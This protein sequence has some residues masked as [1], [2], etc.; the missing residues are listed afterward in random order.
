MQNYNNPNL[1]LQQPQSNMMNGVMGQPQMQSL[2]GNNNMLLG[3]NPYNNYNYMDNRRNSQDLLSNQF[4]KCRPVS[5]KDE[6]RAFQIDLDGSLWVFTDLGNG[7]IY[8]KQV[9]NDG[10]ATF[11][12]YVFTEDENPYS[13]TQYVTKDEF[14]KAIQA[15][16]AAIQPQ[17]SQ[18]PVSA[19]MPDANNGKTGVM[20]F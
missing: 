8:T 7:K 19:P 11:K 4:L 1:N 9:N 10:T 2:Y 15:L 12:T 20:N 14:N 3:N 17:V 18:E 16:S 6:A 13:S 5:S